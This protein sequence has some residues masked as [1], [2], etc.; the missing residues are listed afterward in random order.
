MV[1][2]TIIRTRTPSLE[3][4]GYD[5]QFAI[6]TSQHPYPVS[7]TLYYVQGVLGLP[8][9]LVFQN[10]ND[11]GGLG[12]LHAHTPAVV[13][14]RAA[15]EA[16]VAPQAMAFVAG[17]HL[18]YF[19]PGYYVRHLVPTGTGLKA[20]LFAAIKLSA[21][22]FPIAPEL[23]GQ[24]AEATAAMTAA[25]QGV[26]RE[27]LASQVSKLLQ[28]GT[29][30]DLKKWVTAIDLTADRAGMLLAHNLEVAAEVMRATEETASVAAKDRMKEIVLF[31][32]S[33]PYLELRQKLGISIDS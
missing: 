11:P 33:E 22:Q 12:F 20:W 14:G 24:V 16:Q 2:P 21:P 5:P 32:I 15:F 18:A 19:R 23:E 25:F 28:A 3:S 8:P 26:E 1:Q 17:R 9:T 4:L 30:L 27:L 29:T 6:D 7:Q 10:P 31:S 13:L